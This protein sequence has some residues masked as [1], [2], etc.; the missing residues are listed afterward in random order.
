MLAAATLRAW[1]C[2]A[3]YRSCDA[4]AQRM[5]GCGPS[6]LSSWRPASHTVCRHCW[7]VHADA[8]NP[9]AERR[10]TKADFV[11]MNHA[12]SSEE[13]GMVPVLPVQQLEEIYDR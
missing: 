1:S 5:L 13:G 8:H 3:G 12:S 4:A 11:S 10:L 6:E 7:C 2:H 9:L